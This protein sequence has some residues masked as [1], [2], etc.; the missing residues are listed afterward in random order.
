MTVRHQLFSNL[1]FFPS[2]CELQ[3]IRFNL[4]NKINDEIIKKKKNM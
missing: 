2:K 4:F 3:N 1:T